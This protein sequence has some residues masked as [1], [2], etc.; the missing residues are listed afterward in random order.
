MLGKGGGG[1]TTY[2]QRQFHMHA[3]VNNP[4]TDLDVDA[5]VQKAWKRLKRDEVERR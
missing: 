2:D 3:T 1:D 5:A 4:A